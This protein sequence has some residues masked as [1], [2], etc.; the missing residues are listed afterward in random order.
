MEIVLLFI[1]FAL[2]LLIV[3]SLVY[4]KIHM[5][6]NEKITDIFLILLIFLCLFSFVVLTVIILNI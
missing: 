3:Y 2:I 1:I 4:K 5:F 6:E